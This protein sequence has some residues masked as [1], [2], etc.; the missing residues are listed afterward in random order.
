MI[1]IILSILLAVVCTVIVGLLTELI[2]YRQLKRRGCSHQGLMLASLGLY[3]VLQNIISMI[4]GVRALSIR[5]GDTKIGYE[6]MGAIVSV[7]QIITIVVC[8][9]VF[10]SCIC[11]IKYSRIGRNIRAVASNPELCNVFGISTDRTI[12]LATSIGAVLMAVAGILI[13]YDVDMTPIMGFNWLFYGVVA[14]VIGGVSSNWGLVAG[15]LTLVSAQYITMFYIGSRWMNAV[16]YI[17][18]IIFLIIRP[19]GFSGKRLKKVE[20]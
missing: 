15:T 5:T 14:V 10:I 13:A 3:I 9:V 12:L 18:L 19:L 11:F 6:F 8:S 17:I 16:V 20:I 1:P 7:T 4:W 2:I